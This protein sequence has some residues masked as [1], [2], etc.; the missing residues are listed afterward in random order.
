MISKY[1]LAF[2]SKFVEQNTISRMIQSLNHL[3]SF[4]SNIGCKYISFLQIDRQ[5]TFNNN[6]MKTNHLESEKDA[7]YALQL[8]EGKNV[9]KNIGKSLYYYNLAANK[10]NVQ[11]HF[12]LGLYYYSGIGMK[13]E[14]K[15]KSFKHFKYAAMKGNAKAQYCYGMCLYRGEGVK[16]NKIKGIRYFR[17]SAQNGYDEAQYLYGRCLYEGYEIRKNIDEAEKYFKNAIRQGNKKANFYYDLCMK[18]KKFSKL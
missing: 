16:L 17:L 9:K 5:K 18:N 8:Y 11:A 6:N 14:N 15:E 1:S 13:K 12:A 3:N 4:C 7:N 10:G 2:K